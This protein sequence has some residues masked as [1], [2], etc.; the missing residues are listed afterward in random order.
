MKMRML[1]KALLPAAAIGVALSGY[2]CGASTG[3]YVGVAVP[4][5]Y[6]GYPGYGYPGYI[7]R[8]P[9]VYEEDAL[10]LPVGARENVAVTA[11][12]KEQIDQ[13]SGPEARAGAVCTADEGVQTTPAAADRSSPQ[14]VADR[15]GGR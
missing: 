12:S 9:Y 7:G 11:G 2:G 15:P 14:S 8:P 13:Q 10:N 4:G 3:V 5:P 1:R 6:I